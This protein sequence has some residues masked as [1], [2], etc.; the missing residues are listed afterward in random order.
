MT[1]IV[2]LVP[3]RHHSQRV[4]GKNYRL[5]ARK[6][7]FHHIL[8]TLRR[9][10][11]IAEIAVDTDSEP[12]AQGLR[13]HFPD[14]HVIPRPPDLTADDISM[15]DILAH[16]TSVVDADYYVQTHTTNPLLR[17]ETIGRAI[18]AFLD[19]RADHDSLFSVTR[20][21]TRLRSEERRVGK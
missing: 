8:Q 9:V 18:H 4:P 20:W 7:L 6:P 15:N 21:Q 12:I 16:D 1:R 5:L 10:P 2:A 17:A 3:M 11:E 14:V 19:A 13:D